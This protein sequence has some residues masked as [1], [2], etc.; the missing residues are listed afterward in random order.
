MSAL[1]SIHKLVH[2]GEYVV[3][4]EI[5]LVASEGGWSP[6]ISVEDAYRLDE[7]RAALRAGDLKRA[8][9]LGRLFKLT[10]VTS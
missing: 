8:Q 3:D 7:A 5:K 1:K 2:E 6:Y 10:P 9:Q 4:V